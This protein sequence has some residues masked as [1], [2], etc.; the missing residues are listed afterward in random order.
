MTGRALLNRLYVLHVDG[1][2]PE[3]RA[4]F[5]ALMTDPESALADQQQRTLHTL[6][7]VGGEI[8]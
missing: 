2:S 3:A 6:A 8:G 4:D 7:L 1:L 5:D